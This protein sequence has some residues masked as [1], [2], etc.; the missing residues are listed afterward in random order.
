MRTSLATLAI[1]LIGFVALGDDKDARPID[2]EAET[3][4][5]VRLHHPELASVLEPLKTMDLAEYAKA[6]RELSQVA[7]NL[8]DLKVRN[9]K[10][11][12]VMLDAWKAK[13]RVELLAARLANAPSEELTSE[14]RQAIAVKVEVEIRRNRFD[15]EQAEAVVK[16]ARENIDRLENNREAVIE[17]RLRALKPKKPAKNAKPPVEG[18]PAPKAGKTPP[19]AITEG[20][21]R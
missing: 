15:L 13:S 16:K 18:K 20:K 2:G 21:A 14:L 5:F 19:A 6:I 9:P 8:A 17:A 1:V 7:R 11:Y 3:L 10:R 12:E 4:A